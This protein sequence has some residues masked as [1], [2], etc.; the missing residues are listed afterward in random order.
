[1]VTKS[2]IFILV[3]LM[4]ITAGCGG[5]GVFVPAKVITTIVKDSG[6]PVSV[7]RLTIDTPNGDTDVR[8]TD[9][10]G[11]VGYSPCCNG[12]YTITPTKD[13][14]TFDPPSKTVG[15]NGVF[16]IDVTFEAIPDGSNETFTEYH[17]YDELT[18][19]L[20]QLEDT[21]PSISK[22]S[23]IGQSHET[24]SIWALKISDNVASDEA[25]PVIYID[26]AIHGNEWIG[27]EAALFTAKHLLEN[28][29]S[30]PII[31]NIVD[32]AEIWIV[33]ML[34][35]DGH[36]NLSNQP[37][38][39]A[40][41]LLEVGRKNRMDTCCTHGVDLNRNYDSDWGNTAYGASHDPTSMYYCGP[42]AFS[43]PET[44]AVRDLLNANPPSASISYHS[45]GQYI[46]YAGET[47]SASIYLAQNMSTLIG[48]V[49]GMHYDS[50][51]TQK[52]GGAK[53]WIYDTFSC[54]A[55]VIELRPDEGC[56]YPGYLLPHEDIAPTVEESLAG[57]VFLFEWAIDNY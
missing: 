36:S 52:S 29:E 12:D 24:R 9:S 14:Y 10:D 16:S 18:S 1:M 5:G 26:G 38:P 46:T 17:Q 30:D 33:P 7:V 34:N 50:R 54:P 15:W 39:R 20:S 8:F 35:P 19:E 43:E 45:Y 13:G 42:N 47:D 56:T 28:Y 44:S 2:V 27:V 57:S 55:F 21:Y 51:Y 6:A 22:L 4:V 41:S 49:N 32:N 3:L 40:A 53:E 23:I 11:D 37:F 31:Q 48:A 25:E